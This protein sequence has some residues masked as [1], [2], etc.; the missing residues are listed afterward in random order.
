[1]QRRHLLRL[2]AASA[3]TT[4]T[5][6]SP[7]A[8]WAS[9]QQALSTTAHLAASGAA[10]LSAADFESALLQAPEL[11]PLRGWNGQ[12]RAAA[13]LRIEGRWP[14]GLQGTLYRNG[15][16]L[17]SRGGERYRH[18]FDGDGLVQAWTFEGGRA[19]H[20]ARFVQ[21]AKFK[22]EQQAGRFLLPALGTAIPPQL[23]IQ[24]SDSLN[25]ANTSVLPLDGRLYAL[26]EGG[27]AYE[28]DA[29]TLATRGPKAWAPELQA[30]PFSAHPKVEPDGRVWNFGTA[31]QRLMIYQLSP[32]GEL[33][34]QQLLKLPMAAM[35][36]DFA[37]SQRFLVFL[38]APIGLDM[39]K[40]RAGQSMADAMEWRGQDATRVLALDKA[41]LTPRWFELPAA[42]VFHFGNAW[43]DGDELV[44][45]YVEAPPLP[46]FQDRI[47]AMMSG[48]RIAAVPS[49]PR[50]LRLPLNGQGAPR[51]E[52]R[53]EQVEFPVVDPRVVA[54]RHRFVYYPTRVA[55]PDRW[56][57]DGVMRLDLESGQ[58]QRYQFDGEVL[59]EEQLLVPRPGSTREG[60]GW[61]LG[62]GYDTRRQRS[63]ASVF[64]A[65][66]LADG[67]LARAWLPYWV[68]LGF[69]GRFAARG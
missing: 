32:R 62:L 4:A 66:R 10:A 39:A 40:V 37:V 15:P 2:A 16:G 42:M 54:Q 51:W 18:W 53:D 52:G 33:Q 22:A 38:L 60:Q 19:R 1:M 25:V 14:A 43:D 69:H 20:Q 30:M 28:M 34:R 8:A 56:G 24:N 13:A 26:W 21:T 67:P 50:L 31:M 63:F 7:L 17:M 49:R 9:A 12:D 3:A 45:D 57:F 58:R 64:D 68:P 48:Q 35:V 29:D 36:H 44:L 27:S 41:T 59:L 6:V 55:R 47:K 65:E 23:P 11:L 46:Q 5:A 61:L